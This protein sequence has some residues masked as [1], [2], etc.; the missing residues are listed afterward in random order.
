M[1]QRANN[2][3]HIPDSEFKFTFARSSGAGG[4]NV[5]KTS[6]KVII[7]WSVGDSRVLSDEEKARVRA[8]LA[9]RINSNDELVVMSEEER[10]QPQNRELAVS[11]LRSLVAQALRTPKKRCPTR[12]TKASKL[13]RIESK[14]IQSRKKGMRGKIEE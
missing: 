3:L 5:N 1:S 6:T 9:N 2:H 11:R 4:Q 7:H 13:R 12:P 14:K 10:S 8:K